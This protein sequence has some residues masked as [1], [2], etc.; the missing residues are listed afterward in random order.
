M[1]KAHYPPDPLQDWI[2]ER[3]VADEMLWKG[4]WGHQMSFLRDP[5][6]RVA[7]TGLEWDEMKQIAKVISTHMSKSVSLPVVEYTR[8]DLGLRLIV[9]NNFYNWKL[10]VVSKT[11][12]KADFSGLFHTTL[13]KQPKYTGNPLADCYFEG[14]PN[15]L[16]FGYYSQDKQKFSAKID[17]DEQLYTTFFLIM[18]ALGAVKP[19]VWSTEK[20]HSAQLKAQ[21]DA[22]DARKKAYEEGR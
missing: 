13:P 17:S 18:R 6:R 15:N 12:I 7:A 19:F 10:S 4:S 9:R 3:V 11:P 20:T 5:L 2:T 8:K 21:S 1:G 16:I 14:F 22:F